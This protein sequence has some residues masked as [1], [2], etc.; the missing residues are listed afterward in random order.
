MATEIANIPGQ[1]TVPGGSHCP[2]NR[3]FVGGDRVGENYSGNPKISGR[4]IRALFLGK[5][6][7]FAPP[8]PL[9]CLK[10]KNMSK[11]SEIN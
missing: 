2:R 4:Y 5:G 8:R 11:N 3:H 7:I 9:M 1:A 10:C 6:V